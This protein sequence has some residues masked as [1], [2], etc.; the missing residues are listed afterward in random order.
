MVKPVTLL[1]LLLPFSICA[2]VMDEPAKKDN[3]SFQPLDLFDLQWITEPQISPDGDRIVYTRRGFDV[4]KDQGRSSLWIIDTTGEH[5]EPLTSSNVNSSSPKWSPRGDRL[6]YVSTA[7]G[8]SQIH[9]RWLASGRDIAITNLQESPTALTWSP[10]G[11]RLAF[12]KF[13]PKKTKPIG[14]LPEKPK[15]AEWS[16]EARVF[17]DSYYRSNAEGF[18]K[19]GKNQLFIVSAE[20][21]KPIQLT[22]GDFPHGGS[23]SWTPDNKSIYYSANYA[24]NWQI[25]LGESNIFRIDVDTRQVTKITERDGPDLSP[26]VSPDGQWL[27]YR[28]A[29]DVKKYQDS[30][31]Y[32]T[33]TKKH[34]PRQLFQLDRPITAARWSADSKNV[35]FSYVDHSVTKISSSNLQGKLK[36]IATSLG[37]SAIGRPYS[38]GSF[39]VQ[40]FSRR[41]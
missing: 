38:S 29:D 8:S 18:L 27:L 35:Y 9:V 24:E 6:A 33:S 25:D 22:I 19:P 17:E 41:G 12:V 40:K 2:A 36:P 14:K 4:M 28:G 11:S 32:V 26:Q 1:I 34:Q 7:N 30:K 3:N 10:D 16:E 23:L 5:H 13:V 21:G 37:G 20:G 15:G 39:S 31:L